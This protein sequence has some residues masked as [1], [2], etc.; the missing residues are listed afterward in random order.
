LATRSSRPART[1]RTFDVPQR[2]IADDI[3]DAV[4]AHVQIM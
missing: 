3:G 1:N 2:V 4:L